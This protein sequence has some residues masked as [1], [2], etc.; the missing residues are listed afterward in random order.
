M[1]STFHG[2]AASGP[3]DRLEP[4]E[5]NPGPLN[6]EYVEVEVESCGIC[7]SDLSMLDNEWG[8][9]T[10]P[11]VPG[12][13][14]AGKIVAAGDQVKGLK[15]GQSVGV[16]WYSRSCMHCGQ[17]LGGDHNLCPDNEE[18][19]VGR[20]GGFADRVRCHWL[21]ATPLPEGVDAATAGPL[22]CGGITVFNPIIQAGVKSTDRVGVVGIGGLGHMAVQ[23]LA[24]WGCDVTA[25][26][27]SDS[28]RDEAIRLGARQTASSS[29]KSEMAKLA[30]SLDFILVTANVPMDWSAYL[31][32]L[33][34]RGRLHFVGAVLAPLNVG[35]FDLLVSQKTIGASPLGSPET[36]RRMLDFCA[37]HKIAPQSE[38]FP[39]SQVNEALDRL[40]AGKARYRIILQR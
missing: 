25:F 21:W 40:R 10:Y 7:H 26:T 17:C 38:F 27:S 1:S 9:T 37:R 23:F 8:R 32:T 35:V 34:P 39:M 6:P 16:G 31:A 11:F 19:I 12:H 22:F 28:K 3:K 15:V 30:S 24:K 20:H 4:F 5:F 2:Y 18:T 29:N 33:R 14:V 36:T 13:E